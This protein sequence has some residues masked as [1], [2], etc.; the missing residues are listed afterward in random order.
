MSR[1]STTPVADEA[2]PELHRLHSAD[3]EV[4]GA[5][6]RRGSDIIVVSDRFGAVVWVSP[7]ISGLGYSSEEFVGK[8]GLDLVH[9]DDFEVA[10]AAYFAADPESAAV[11]L[12]VRHADGSWRHLSVA[13]TNLIDDPNVGGIVANAR[14]ITDRV[15]AEDAL[16]RNEEW[17]RQFASSAPVGIIF[18]DADSNVTYVNDRWAEITGIPRDEAIGR[19]WERVVHPDDEDRVARSRASLAQDGRADVDC[20]IVRAD[21]EVIWVHGQTVLMRGSDAATVG[22]VSAIEDV[23]A[24][25]AARERATRW[26]ALAEHSLDMVSIYDSEGRFVYV[27]PSRERVL[28]YPKEELIGAS[29][30]DQLHPDERDEVANAFT[31]Q[32]LGT[33]EPVPVQH[34]FLHKDGSWRYLESL[35]VDL[36]GD[37]TIDG[38][39]VNSRDVTD[40]RRAELV[41]AEQ[42][43]ILEGVAR[44]IPLRSTLA[45]VVEMIERWTPGARGVI[46]QIDAQ[47]DSLHVAAAPSLDSSVV[48]ALEGLAVGTT[49]KETYPAGF[50][51][52]PLGSGGRYPEAAR[53]LVERGFRSWW[54][55]PMDDPSGTRRLG[56]VMV[57][58]RDEVPA[59]DADRSLME[60]AAALAAVAHRARSRRVPARAPGAPRRADRPAEP[61]PGGEPAAAG[62]RWRRLG[63]L[64][65]GRAVPRPRPLQ[66]AERQR[67]P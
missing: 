61:R 43:R 58:R 19:C 8:S 46:T 39:L 14:D 34:R 22:F 35:A 7:S 66:G 51:V 32:L 45:V 31:E 59:S 29:P 42:A 24:D 12:R 53:A 38:I 64:A 48:D 3:A 63:R 25:R 2:R 15:E 55:C 67:R 11:R 27:S 20:R 47:T 23:T 44:G 30:I 17:F 26:A 62:D 13:Y 21:G 36:R 28:G 5:L 4:L 18:C 33:N 54:A 40:R 60:L 37:P 1:G 6:V 16:R 56:A 50:F 65:H 41:T 49:V 57:L 52:A 9:P 10:F